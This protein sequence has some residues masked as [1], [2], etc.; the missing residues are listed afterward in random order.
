V[1][2]AFAKLAGLRRK[3]RSLPAREMKGIIRRPR[4]P[5]SVEDMRKAVARRAG[6]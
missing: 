2:A 6:R 4:K 3:P 5:V 1:R